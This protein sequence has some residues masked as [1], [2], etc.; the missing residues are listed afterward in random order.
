VAQRALG[1]PVP[2]LQPAVRHLSSLPSE[3]CHWLQMQIVWLLIISVN[4]CS[5]VVC[6]EAIF[7]RESCGIIII[8]SALMDLYVLGR[9]VSDLSLG[10]GS[11]PC[12]A[13]AEQSRLCF[14]SCVM[15]DWVSNYDPAH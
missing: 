7:Q 9:D 13:V 12:G 6:F 15:A 2:S 3:L 4:M 5:S 10:R 1:L 8:K 11:I 14:S